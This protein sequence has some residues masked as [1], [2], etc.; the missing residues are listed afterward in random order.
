QWSFTAN[1]DD[2]IV[3]SVGE[4]QIPEIDPGFVPWIRLFGPNG[5]EVG[6]GYGVLVG[7]I[8]VTAPL[9]GTYTVVVSSGDAYRDA[10][11]HYQIT[12]AKMSGTF[13]VP[14][15]DAGGWMTNTVAY[16]CFLHVGAMYQWNFAATQA[17]ALAVGV[18]ETM[19]PE[20]DP[21]FVPWIRLYGPTG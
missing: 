11:G 2:A 18:S 12:L 9:T 17:H 6:S 3:L 13:V 4:T 16:P 1:K 7:Q 14:S 10:S 8:A 20:I 19:I 21:G 5:A 15:G